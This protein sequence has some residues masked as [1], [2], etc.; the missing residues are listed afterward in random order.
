MRDLPY[1]LN[2]TEG[3]TLNSL[4]MKWEL[5]ISFGVNYRAGMA[6]TAY[7][8]YILYVVILAMVITTFSLSA[9]SLAP[10][11]EKQAI[12]TYHLTLPVGLSFSAFIPLLIFLIA[13]ILYFNSNSLI[14]NILIDSSALAVALLN[15]VNYIVV[16]MIWKPLIYVL[17]LFVLIKYDS[18]S[19]LQLDWG[20]IALIIFIYRVYSFRKKAPSFIKARA[21]E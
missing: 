5:F 10:S 11:S 19:T 9:A 17:P 3:K 8:D 6:T 7:R 15:Y 12:Y 14:G 2:S 20:Q 16:W 4:R 18:A 13:L 1:T 21:Q